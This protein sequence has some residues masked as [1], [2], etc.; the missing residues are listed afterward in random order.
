MLGFVRNMKI[1]FSEDIFWF[2]SYRSWYILHGS[3]RLTFSEILR[4]SCMP[5]SQILT[6][7]YHIYWKVCSLTDIWQLF[8]FCVSRD[9]AIEFYGLMALVCL[10]GLVWLLCFGLILIYSA[11]FRNGFLQVIY[12]IIL[13]DKFSQKAKDFNSIYMLTLWEVTRTNLYLHI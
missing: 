7:I 12:H 8:S 6:L 4:S 9:G 1:F 3:L 11:K 5:C 10:L 13:Y 2:Q